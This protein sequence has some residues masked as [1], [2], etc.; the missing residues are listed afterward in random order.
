MKIV[1]AI[2]LLFYMIVVIYHSLSEFRQGKKLEA[3]FDLLIFI[4]TALFII[5]TRVLLK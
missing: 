2:G 1:L 4:V 3:I 5:T